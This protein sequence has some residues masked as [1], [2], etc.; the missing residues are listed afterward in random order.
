MSHRWL[1]EITYD[2]NGAASSQD[3][4]RKAIA[5]W[6]YHIMDY[7]LQTESCGAGRSWTSTEKNGSRGSFTGASFLF[8]DSGNPFVQADVG[9]YIVIKD[10]TNFAT[11]GVYKIIRLV[12]AGTVEIDFR[13]GYQ[14]YPSAAADLSWWLLASSYQLPTVGD[15]IRLQSRH[16]TGW[17]IEICFRDWPYFGLSFRL[18]PS[19]DWVNGP[20]LGTVSDP[21]RA[22]FGF[23]NWGGGG[24]GRQM[25]WL[26]GDYTNCESLWIVQ[27]VYDRGSWG[28]GNRLIMLSFSMLDPVEP[29][30]PAVDLVVMKG[31]V[32]ESAPSSDPDVGTRIYDSSLGRG[33]SWCTRTNSELNGYSFDYSSGSYTAAFGRYQP[34]EPNRRRG[35]KIEFMIGHP[36]ITDENNAYG[37]YA[38]LGFFKGHWTTSIFVEAN[39]NLEASDVNRHIHKLFPVTMLIDR[40][41]LY[42]T[43]GIVV[44]WCGLSLIGQGII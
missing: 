12:S 18:A 28:E 22:S 30:L 20:I 5:L 25:F 33:V 2:Y 44:P 6:I 7:T 14:E 40:D 37:G 35:D 10:D 26:I 29:G 34:R 31:A 16:S 4:W 41:C 1:R 21:N 8:S 27:S 13:S 38:I 42:L 39:H 32:I 3:F 19:G 11:G 36:Y 15:Y 17:A 43:D 9:K 24:S 23:H